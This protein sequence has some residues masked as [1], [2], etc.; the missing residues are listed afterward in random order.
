MG[1]NE[2][3]KGVLQACPGTHTPLSS[4]KVSRR[5]WET[6]NFD[7]ASSE[8][9]WYLSIIRGGSAVMSDGFQI[10]PTSAPDIGQRYG[11]IQPPGCSDGS[12]PK[13]RSRQVC[14]TPLVSMI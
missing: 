13:L 9:F 12:D 11:R 2:R 5:S 10:S 6:T 3:R 1:N 4:D 8:A 14:K 7:E